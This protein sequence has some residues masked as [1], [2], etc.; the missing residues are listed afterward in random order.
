M[1]EVLG[2]HPVTGLFRQLARAREVDLLGASLDRPVADYSSLADLPELAYGRFR[3]AAQANALSAVLAVSRGDYA[4]AVTRL[5]ENA[6]IAE[7]FLRVPRLFANQ[8]GIGMLQDLAILPLADLERIRGDSGLADQLEAAAD[9][10]RQE[11]FSRGWS[12]G[13]IGLAADPEHLGNYS[14]VLVDERVLPGHRVE[15]FA[16]AWIGLCLNPRELISG[17]DPGRE[18]TVLSAAASMQVPHADDLARL[19]IVEWPEESLAS[20][21]GISDW[22]RRASRL[23]SGDVILRLSYCGNLRT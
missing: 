15:S 22:A 17:R 2:N 14:A 12:L 11:G 10:L 3:E 19:A 23:P 1:V 4:G 6:A 13:M 7:H 20:R 16:G 8:F 18:R 9:G 21:P 5:G